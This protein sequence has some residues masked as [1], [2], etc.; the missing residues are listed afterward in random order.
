MLPR[1]LAVPNRNRI[2]YMGGSAT[3][4][5]EVTNV[6]RLVSDFR[7]HDGYKTSTLEN[8]ICL[9][10]FDQ[11]VEFTDTIQPICFNPKDVKEFSQGY[12]GGWGRNSTTQSVTS[13]FLNEAQ[14][15]VSNFESCKQS[16][17]G[18]LDTKFH[19]CALGLGWPVLYYDAGCPLSKSKWSTTPLW[20]FVY[21]DTCGKRLPGVYTSQKLPP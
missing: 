12:L 18:I 4:D 15:T 20:N 3:R 8:D 5:D 1:R 19:F 6:H 21:G 9:V 10:K 13:A 2:V 11:P 7:R 17:D 14:M 16:Y